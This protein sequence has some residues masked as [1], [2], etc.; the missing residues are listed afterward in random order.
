M[1]KKYLLIAS[2]FI[3]FFSIQSFAVVTPLRDE[4]PDLKR[5]SDYS[6]GVRRIVKA[7]KYESKN[8]YKKAD[9]LYSEA[10]KFFLLANKKTPANPD[11]Y[12][13]LGF[14]SEKIKKTLDAEIYYLLGLE[15]SPNDKKINN[16]LGKLYFKNNK[17]NK[18]KERLKVL[19]TCECKEYNDLASIIR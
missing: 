17:I 11:V 2:I 19:E 10:L 16:F 13:Y 14:T 18:A 4:L 8:K 1:I 9:K 12:F 5:L 6:I 15:I 7:L 3:I